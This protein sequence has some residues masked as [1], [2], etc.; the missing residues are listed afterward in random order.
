MGNTIRFKRELDYYTVPVSVILFYSYIFK[1]EQLTIPL[2]TIIS[3]LVGWLIWLTVKTFQNDKAIAVN[4]SNDETVSSKIS[5]L[6][7]D[8]EK[9]IDKF[10]GHVNA[11]FDKV[12]EKIEQ[13]TRR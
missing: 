2:L 3:P 10:E 7:N 6:K 4:T 9:R 12:F 5:E 11:K 8:V 13:I 1:M